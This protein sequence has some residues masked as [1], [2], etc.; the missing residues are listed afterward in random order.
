M[1]EQSIVLNSRSEQSEAVTAPVRS[2]SLVLRVHVFARTNRVPALDWPG[3]FRNAACHF[4]CDA[5]GCDT[6]RVN[7]NRPSVF[8]RS[9]H[10]QVELAGLR[11]GLL[12]DAAS[13]TIEGRFAE[14]EG[15][16]A[17][18]RTGQGHV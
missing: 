3:K 15:D 11:A 14:P 12:D 18:M 2:L 5:P 10:R 16:P 4:L 17:R 6:P 7:P 13:H 8:R 9:E 1:S